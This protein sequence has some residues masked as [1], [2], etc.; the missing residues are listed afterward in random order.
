MFGNNTLTIPRAQVCF[1]FTFPRE[2]RPRFRCIKPWLRGRGWCRI[3]DCWGNRLGIFLLLWGVVIF[4]LLNIFW[5]F[6]TLGL[7]QESSDYVNLIKWRSSAGV[8][9]CILMFLHRTFKYNCYETVCLIIFYFVCPTHHPTTNQHPAKIR[10]EPQVLNN[11][12][13]V[14]ARYC[15]RLQELPHVRSTSMRKW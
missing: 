4:R 9:A 12:W 8:S 7:L 2:L 11:D 6:S 10:L 15:L 1:F 3:K 5:F 13:R 14:I